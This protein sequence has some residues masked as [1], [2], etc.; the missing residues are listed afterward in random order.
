MNPKGNNMNIQI[1]WKVLIS[2]LTFYKSTNS[3]WRSN[4]R[5]IQINK[6]YIKPSFEVAENSVKLFCF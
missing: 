1:Y 3:P 5:Q 2:A 6:L 4:M